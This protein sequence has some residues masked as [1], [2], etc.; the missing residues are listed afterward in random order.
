MCVCVA[1]KTQIT[2]EPKALVLFSTSLFFSLFP[3]YM[4]E[5]DS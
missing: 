5:A 3:I 1:T 4:Y 2:D